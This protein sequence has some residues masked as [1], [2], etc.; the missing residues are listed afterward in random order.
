MVSTCT[1][2]FVD[3]GGAD[4]DNVFASTPVA[5]TICPGDG[6]T[7]IRAVFSTIDIG[8]VIR[9]FNGPNIDAPLI[10]IVE[11][12]LNGR[13]I[14]FRATAANASGCLTFQFTSTLGL[15]PGEGWEA[16]LSCVTPCQPI[17]AVLLEADPT[18]VPN[19]ENGYIDV[20]QGD[21]IV[22]TGGGL[23]PESGTL[24][25][26]SD[27]T[28]GF[29]WNFQNGD[30]REGR[31]VTY[32]F[33]EP[34]GYAVQLQIE[35]ENGCLNGNRLTQRV[36]VS[37]SPE[38]TFA[39]PLPQA[40][41]PGE[42]VV[43]DIDDPTDPSTNFTVTPIPY[44]FATG[45]SRTETVFLPDGRGETY[46][47]PL[48]FTNFDPGQVLQE[49]ADIVRICAVIEH[50]WLGDLDIALECPDGTAIKLHEFRD[51]DMTVGD[52]RLGGGDR[53][54]VD[55]DP[56]GTYCWTASASETMRELVE[57]RNLTARSLPEIDYQPD[58]DLT[59]LVGCELNGEWTIAVTDF[60][61]RDEGYIFEWSID[62]GTDV[63]PEQERFTVAITDVQ[64][65]QNDFYSEFSPLRAVINT[66]VPGPKAVVIEAFDDYG[67]SYD[68]AVTVLVR[69]P[70]DDECHTCPTYAPD[71]T[72]M[73]GV[74]A[75][76]NFVA[77]AGLEGIEDT[78]VTYRAV[79]H[80]LVG[81]AT[82]E[83]PAIPYISELTI[84]NHNPSTIDDAAMDI[85]EICLDVV[86]ADDLA[87][88][89]AVLVSPGGTELTL[90]RGFAGNGGTLARTCFTATATE[91]LSSS[92][93]APYT[94]D[95]R[96]VSDLGA[97][98]GQPSNGTWQLRMV[99]RARGERSELVAWSITLR[100]DRGLR[101]SWTGGANLD[102]S[103]TDCLNPT[104]TPDGPGTARLTLT[105]AK[106]CE[107]TVTLDI[108]ENAI[109]VVPAAT[110]S[111]PECA[112]GSEG[113]ITL[114]GPG[115][116]TLSY[117]WST[118]A[119]TP[120]ITGLT[121]GTYVV[122]LTNASGCNQEISFDV[123]EPTPV[124]A[125]KVITNVTCN[126]NV[127]GAV[128]YT[129][130]GGT[131]PYTVVWPALGGLTTEDVSDLAAGTYTVEI[132]D[133]NGCGPNE[134]VEITEPEP[135][136]ATTGFTPVV[137]RGEANGTATA[138][139]VGGTVP[140]TFAWGDGQTDETATGLIAG[141]YS[142]TVTDAQNC[143]STA[144]ATVTQ[145]DEPL[146][147]TVINFL[148]GC[149]EASEGSATASPLGGAGSYTYLWSN[150]ETSVTAVNLPDGEATVDVR[151]LNGCVVQA[152]VAVTS[153]PPV[154][155]AFTP[156]T[157]T[158]NGGSD[159]SL[160]VVATG[161]AGLS[162]ADFTF[163][164]GD[165]QTTAAIS[166]LEGERDY[167]VTA[168]GPN[169]CTATESFTLPT[170][171]PVRINPTVSPVVCF[172]ESN[173]AI[174]L[175]N[176]TGPN[177]GDYAVQW[178]PEADN[179]TGRSID[180]LPAGEYP[181][182]ITDAEGCPLDTSVVVPQPDTLVQVVDQTNVSCFG[183]GDAVLDVG[184]S[185]GTSPY[186]FLWET[187]ATA[188]ELSDLSPGDFPVTLTDVNG[189]TAEEIYTVTEPDLLVANPIVDSISCEGGRNGILTIDA[190]GGTGPFEYQITGRPRGG[191]SSF[192]GLGVGRYDAILTDAN[193]C[194]ADTFAVF[195]DGP[196]FFVDLGPDST[197]VFGDSITLLPS[198]T[199]GRDPLLYDYQPSAPTAISCFD[200][201]DPV[202]RPEFE[203]DYT[204]VLTDDKGCI[205]TDRTRISVL[206]IREVA[207]PTGFSPNGNGSNERLLV[208]GR[209]G[210]RVVSF[211]VYDRWASLL[212]EE[213]DFAVNDP[214]RGWDGTHNGEPVNAGVYLYKAT[215]E[216]DDG[217]RET[218]S[219]QTTLI[220]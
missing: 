152:S 59:G 171:D 20:C 120:A 33:N 133:A 135:L 83:T 140:Y 63:Y 149:A 179:R 118:G 206:K 2:R 39:D 196:E 126:G 178:G 215:I 5:T 49:G 182:N 44:T 214:E 53:D 47:S 38:F 43:I 86:N 141:T 69:S 200:C 32:A 56:E 139:T 177:P 218:I 189:C 84:G 70:F 165:G 13:S 95:F 136:V 128:D 146:T 45:Q 123:T 21:P 109:D 94:G 61:T 132:R 26:Q 129:I 185:G 119:T 161:G 148:P 8:G 98:T 80:G 194:R 151:D 173:G 219:G 187:G 7:S 180:G 162:P 181:V 93:T 201:P 96:P 4:G 91:S 11:T 144:S 66:T 23:Y 41:C 99:D 191:N 72:V 40:V 121:A 112:G 115:A 163:V 34:G 130:S 117:A 217:S 37:P 36:R 29:T 156:V 75:G 82:S 51:R 107:E 145:A 17:E 89:S 22:F 104:I 90:L 6:E 46:R 18:P 103:C 157:P 195:E 9:V 183:E 3:A 164:W 64:L 113:G 62:F 50:S 137:C 204:L 205:A 127:D 169:G 111:Q 193:A 31:S 87:E 116:E 172:G 30:I 54:T 19:D 24:Y 160:A 167:E 175:D 55:P 174:A 198:I 74:C 138:V 76:D 100:Y 170:A 15:T 71:A 16:L 155:L 1:G 166:G 81:R 211:Q 67:C 12:S 210:T 110:L 190:R 150:G 124:V 101:Y 208:H 48:V 42:E 207:V 142:V 134:T 220:R 60:R 102:F 131:P 28:S 105:D 197:I 58:D 143:T 52:Q 176:I 10:G 14:I 199:G 114:S 202:I 77:D 168:T 184:G 65:K 125:E 122:T 154:S 68:T 153:L 25:E 27:A 209:P 158:C 88:L 192:L 213:G 216:Y 147:A 212:F 203:L 186:T 159:G 57:R 106:G 35:D 73:A 79:P 92:S 108:T 188:N 97:L 85:A 78:M